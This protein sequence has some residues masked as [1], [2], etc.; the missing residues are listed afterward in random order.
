MET[1]KS[2]TS[3]PSVEVPRLVSPPRL[4]WM[5][6]EDNQTWAVPKRPKFII[7]G[8]SEDVDALITEIEFSRTAM[9]AAMAR[10][11]RLVA[12]PIRLFADVE[13]YRACERAVFE[14]RM[15]SELNHR[16]R[17]GFLG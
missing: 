13:Q 11:T 4:V 9:G 5:I 12:E 16:T 7:E 17:V 15:I 2:N 8:T 1:T 3:A 6:F 14:S 10:D